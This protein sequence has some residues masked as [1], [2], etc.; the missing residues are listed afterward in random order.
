VGEVALSQSQCRLRGGGTRPPNPRPD[1]IRSP[2]PNQSTRARPGA[3]SRARVQGGVRFALD[4]R[5]RVQGRV[6]FLWTPRVRVQGRVRFFWTPE[7]ESKESP[8]AVGLKSPMGSR[9]RS[10]QNG[11]CAL[12]WG[13]G[14][15]PRHWRGEVP[16]RCPAV[17]SAL[18]VC[19]GS[20]G[21][22][23]YVFVNVHVVEE[24]AAGVCWSC[25][26]ALQSAVSPLAWARL[27]SAASLALLGVTGKQLISSSG[28]RFCVTY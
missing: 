4:P 13:R 28:T 16:A 7:S 18:G 20:C 3:G 1:Q 24:T 23:A 5:A 22:A 15:W 21:S 10:K 14:P 6:R 12:H 8:I 19:S 26:D 27:R 11:L 9:V 25:E 2:S 17:P